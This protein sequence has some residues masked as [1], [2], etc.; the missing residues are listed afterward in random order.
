MQSFYT[1]TGLN[2]CYQLTMSCIKCGTSDDPSSM[3][4]CDSCNRSIH[5]KCSGLSA[6]EVKVMDLKGKRLLKFYCDDCLS[7]LLLVPKLI[8]QIDELKLELQALKTNSNSG[9]SFDDE[10]K[11]IKNMLAEST[12]LRNKEATLQL[13]SE[14]IITEVAERTRRASNIIIFNLEE[15]ESADLKTKIDHDIVKV[16]E[17]ILE[18]TG[19]VI[20][21]IKAIRLGRRTDP[22]K[23]RPLK[24]IL[25][26]QQSALM[27]LRNKTKIR[28]NNI[29]INS[30]QT[31]MQQKHLKDLRENLKSRTDQGED[32]LTIKYLR[33]VPKIVTKNY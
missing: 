15:S 25:D 17:L 5:K 1:R 11:T 9:A 26:S 14:Q 12:Q 33:G 28:N 3:L 6:S 30:D 2:S 8:K 16:N 24:V 18:T 32:N 21:D 31:P 29:K 13:D 10:I 7:G 23:K 4:G 27:I 20:P 22:N 19:K